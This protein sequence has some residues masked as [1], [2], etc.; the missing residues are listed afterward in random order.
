MAIYMPTQKRIEKMQQVAQ[1][2]MRGI[3]AVF[4]DIYDPYPPTQSVCTTNLLDQYD[5]VVRSFT[6]QGRNEFEACGLS[7]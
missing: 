2:R 6:A 1:H 4:E 5:R 7:D 3:I